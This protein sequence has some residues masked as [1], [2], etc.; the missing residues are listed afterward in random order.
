MSEWAGWNEK[1]GGG[2]DETW[3]KKPISYVDRNGIVHY[4]SAPGHGKRRSGGGGQPGQ[5]KGRGKFHQ[6]QR[7]NDSGHGS[8]THSV[9]SASREPSEHPHSYPARG[10]AV[11]EV[12]HWA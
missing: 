12:Q 10:A 5:G 8:T 2:G 4:P 3:Q 11:Q 6:R 1:G 9:W 7:S